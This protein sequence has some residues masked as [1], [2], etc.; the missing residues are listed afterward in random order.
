MFKKKN[1]GWA[2]SGRV[3]SVS[4]WKVVWTAVLSLGVRSVQQV[5]VLQIFCRIVSHSFL[6]LAASSGRVGGVDR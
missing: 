1:A 5:C 4:T 6:S 2:G 3:G